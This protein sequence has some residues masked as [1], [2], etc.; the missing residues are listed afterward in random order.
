M[1]TIP[2][3]RYYEYVPKKTGYGWKWPLTTIKNYPVQGFGA[4]LVKLAR[5]E[6]WGRLKNSQYQD[7][8]KFVQTIHD[9][10]V[11]DVDN[12]DEVVYNICTML[13][14]SIEYTPTLCKEWFDYEFSLPIWCEVQVG[15]NKADMVDYKFN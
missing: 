11:V 4:E 5:V 12:D 2:S 7:R 3:G 6:F 14:D 13:R 10:L 15:P 9:S 8:A 1:L